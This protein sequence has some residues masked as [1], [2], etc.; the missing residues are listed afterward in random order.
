ML[1][2][3]PFYSAIRAPLTH[4]VHPVANRRCGMKAFSSLVRNRGARFGYPSPRNGSYASRPLPYPYVK[5]KRN[6]TSSAEGKR[7]SKSK[8]NDAKMAFQHHPQGKT[9]GWR[10][11]RR[12]HLR[13]ADVGIFQLFVHQCDA[14][15]IPPLFPLEQN[16]V[17]VEDA[18][19]NQLV[20]Q[21]GAW[22][23]GNF[24]RQA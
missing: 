24:S 3:M 21:G 12:T 16:C 15:G 19:L 18:Q 14:H 10:R 20:G 8:T 5:H 23:E 7:H 6:L 1:A 2:N 4:R 9:W 17:P 11:A 13:H 22:T